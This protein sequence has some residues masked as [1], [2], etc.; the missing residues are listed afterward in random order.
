M[1]FVWLG[2]S[3]YKCTSFGSYVHERTCTSV[4]TLRVPAPIDFHSSGVL[5]YPSGTLVF[6]LSGAKACGF[7]LTIVGI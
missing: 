5:V 6:F 2:L 7:H 4:M 3:V 1:C